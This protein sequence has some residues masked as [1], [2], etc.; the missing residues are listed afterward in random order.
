MT[1]VMAWH[2]TP[3]DMLLWSKSPTDV[4]MIT[5]AQIDLG[6][7]ILVFCTY[8]SHH[9]MSNVVLHL[10]LYVQH[11]Q[12][13]SYIF[14]KDVR[15]RQSNYSQVACL[16]SQTIK[17]ALLMIVLLLGLDPVH[18][19]WFAMLDVLRK[20]WNTWMWVFLFKF[21]MNTCTF[22]FHWNDCT[23]RF[24]EYWWRTLNC[25]RQMADPTLVV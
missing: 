20:I 13:Y 22:V 16:C 3:W 9:C 2:Q 19:M 21:D 23:P 24:Y 14:V 10:W 4:N 12:S 8:A 5:L 1:N 25:T 11:V 6:M 15:K 7:I 18:F 17:E